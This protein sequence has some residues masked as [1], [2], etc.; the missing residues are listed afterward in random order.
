[1]DGAIMVVKY[2]AAMTPKPTD[3][4]SAWEVGGCERPGVI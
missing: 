1:M 4:Q 3:L 2:S